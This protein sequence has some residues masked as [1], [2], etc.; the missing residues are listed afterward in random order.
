M[1]FGLDETVKII[2]PLPYF[3]TADVVS[4]I[5]RKVTLTDS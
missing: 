1:T 4:V 5:P 2:P 3:L